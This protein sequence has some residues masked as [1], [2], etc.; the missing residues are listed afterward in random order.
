[1][2]FNRTYVF[3]RRHCLNCMLIS[4]YKMF[5]SSSKEVKY[6]I[7]SNLH[8]KEVLEFKEPDKYR[9]WLVFEKFT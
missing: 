7:D 6:K 1:M 5:L 2:M 3:N 8:Y 4:V 9:P